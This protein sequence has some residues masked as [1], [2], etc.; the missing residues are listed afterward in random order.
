[1]LGVVQEGAIAILQRTS[2]S[3]AVPV[4]FAISHCNLTREC[5]FAPV[6]FSVPFTRQ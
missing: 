1:L 4:E 5:R 2:K 3:R 6:L